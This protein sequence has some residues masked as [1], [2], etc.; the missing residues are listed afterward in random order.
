MAEDD[1]TIRAELLDG[2]SGPARRAEAATERLAASARRAGQAAG[3]PASSGISAMAGHT[4]RLAR[5][6]GQADSKL[7]TMSQTVSNKVVGALKLAAVGFVAAGAAAI[8]FGIKTAAS[9]EQSMIQLESLTGSATEAK[10]IFEFLKKTDPKTPFDIKQLLQVTTQLSSAGLEGDKLKASIQGVADVAASAGGGAESISRI[11]LAISQMSAAGVVVQQDLNQL[12]QAGVNVGPAL[13]KASGMSLAEFRKRGAGAQVDSDAF[14]QILFGMRAGTAQKMATETLTGLWSS[15]RTR[16]YLAASSAAAPL[17]QAIKGLLPG[18]ESGVGVLLDQVFPPLVSVATKLLALFVRGLP[19]IAPVLKAIASGLDNLIASATPAMKG[20]GGLGDVG[21]G[22]GSMFSSLAGVMPDVVRLVVNLV[23]LLPDMVK[24]LGFLV[25]LADPL[26]KLL[27]VLLGFEPTR[28]IFAGLLVTFLGYYKLSGPIKSMWAF[29]DALRGIAGAQEAANLA[30]TGGGGLKPGDTFGRKPL[31]KGGKGGGVAGLASTV[32]PLVGVAVAAGKQVV[33]GIKTTLDAH[34]LGAKAV[35]AAR[36][37]PGPISL[38]AGGGPLGSLL[39]KVNPFGDTA[40]P[41]A[42]SGLPGIP[43]L[44]GG[45]GLT[46]TSG[47]RSWGL[48]GLG[49]DHLTG[50]A[51]DVVGPHLNN[52]RFN[53]ERL[54]GFAEFHG[55]GNAR[56]LHTVAGDTPRPRPSALGEMGGGITY[57][58][59]FGDIIANYPGDIEAEVRRGMARAEQDRIERGRKGA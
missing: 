40:R 56:H 9:I 52:V 14:L 8:T 55:E 20:L 28:M 2:V 7:V 38:L 48:G 13:V 22:L 43:G 11:G 39:Q 23:R 19:L 5:I 32:L 34:G 36:T 25:V 54:G 12:V 51:Q 24:F 57:N 10:N 44:A 58:V 45:S 27:N 1:L 15:V 33:D 30:N 26:I 53:L 46:V 35:S 21:S 41:W 47:Q 17:N 59:S 37:I 29:A 3:G 16:F 4:D 49:S 42:G 18:L 50:R 31:S 6:A